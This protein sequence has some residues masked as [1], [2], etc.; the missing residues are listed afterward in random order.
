LEIIRTRDGDEFVIRPCPPWCTGGHFPPDETVDS[1]DGFHHYGT[2]VSIPTSHRP[3]TGGESSTVRLY[4]STWVHPLDAQPPTGRVDVTL[5]TADNEP[6]V[7]LTA[8][9]ARALA[10]ALVMLADTVERGDTGKP[11]GHC[12]Q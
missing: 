9:E 10:A 4:L 2:E 8:A 7:E 5:F 11:V 1:D 6:T 3:F 12:P